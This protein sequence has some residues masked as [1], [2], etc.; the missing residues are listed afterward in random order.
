MKRDPSHRRP[1]TR[2]HPLALAIALAFCEAALALPQGEKTVAGQVSVM[3]P[4]AGNMLIQQGSAAGI[5][6]WQ[7]FSI[8]PGEAVRIQ[9]PTASSVLLNRVIGSDPSN[10]FGQLSANG[11]VFL[12]NPSGV[13]FGP[14]A[15]V[16]VGSLVASTLSMRDEDFLAGR[17]SFTGNGGATVNE[18]S[19]K[20]AERGTVALLGGTV[21]NDGSIEARLGTVALAAGSRI[22]LDLAGDGLSRVAV[23]QAA[24]DAQVANGGAIVADGGAVLLTAGALDA[25]V[26]GAVNHS[27][28]VRARSL[29]ERD[30]RIVLDSGDGGA[31]L[32]S[33][34]LDATG[35][36]PGT[37]GGDIQVLGRQVSVTGSAQ[38]DAS[39]PAGGGAVRVGGD[40]QGKNQDVRNAATTYIGS[41]ASLRADA[42]ERGDGGK[43]K[44][45]RAHV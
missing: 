40:A 25:L 44:I 27:G 43:V 33:G 3:R 26:G 24:I 22:T 14:G 18:G 13:L 45:G 39:G 37:R 41:Q 17:Y 16:D 9:Q 34:T 38:L 6:N 1:T 31:T 30:G 35:S 4:S 12:L 5:V 2:L 36:A 7:S 19:I 11:K 28:V 42:T 15:R 32:V 23:T 10:I 29:V 8:D 20:A 21:R